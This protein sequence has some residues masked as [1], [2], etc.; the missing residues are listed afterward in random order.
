[1]KKRWIVLGGIVVVLG[2]AAFSAA[3]LLFQPVGTKSHRDAVAFKPTSLLDFHNGYWITE[4]N[5]SWAPV[6]VKAVND[7]HMD[8]KTG[9]V[10]VYAQASVLGSIMA[11]AQVAPGEC[12][13]VRGQ[14]VCAH[15]DAVYLNG[16]GKELAQSDG[17]GAWWV[18]HSWV[19]GGEGYDNCEL[20]PAEVY[21]KC[22]WVEGV[23]LDDGVTMKIGGIGPDG[24]M[25]YNTR[26]PVFD[27]DGFYYVATRFG[28]TNSDPDAGPIDLTPTAKGMVRLECYEEPSPLNGVRRGC[29]TMPLRP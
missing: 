15:P 13:E 25:H 24:A 16:S 28:P 10:T 18:K 7:L 1:M 29:P 2:L 11:P 26:S 20:K 14:R 4:V 9:R 21:D 8:P 19:L 5:L 6:P 27:R 22:I 12:T 23:L 3:T 17:T